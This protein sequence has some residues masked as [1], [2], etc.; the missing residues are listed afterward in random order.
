MVGYGVDVD[1]GN[2]LGQRGHGCE[3]YWCIRREHE[4]GHDDI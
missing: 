2:V 1:Q 3:R 4:S